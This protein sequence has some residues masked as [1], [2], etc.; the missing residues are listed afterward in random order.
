LLA[1]YYD[2]PYWPIVY[3]VHRAAEG[4]GIFLGFL[5]AGWLGQTTAGGRPTSCSPCRAW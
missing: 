3:S 4:L 2:V 5:L 1:D